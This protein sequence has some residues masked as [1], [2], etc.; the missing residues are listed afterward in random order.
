M[1]NVARLAALLVALLV[2]G[3]D[4]AVAGGGAAVPGAFGVLLL[5]V[6]GLA[7]RRDGLITAAGLA[8]AAHYVVA[9]EFGDVA[10][11]LAAPFV[12]ALVVVF[13]DLGDLALAL[14]ND[15]RVDPLLLR[16]SA[17]HAGTA[18]VVATVAGVLTYALAAAPW[19][20]AE[21]FRAVGALGVAV[22]VAAPLLLLRRAP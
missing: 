5:V 14:P 7:W 4:V 2:L 8:L 20:A 10:V 3:R 18:L 11:D 19:P 21:W 17:R 15:R 9:L 6:G 16:S 22:V 1:R 12:G 13:L